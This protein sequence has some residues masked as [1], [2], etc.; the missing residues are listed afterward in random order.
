MN[1]IIHIV[2]NT[3]PYIRLRSFLHSTGIIKPKEPKDYYIS[4]VSKDAPWT[5]VAYIAS[6]FYHLE[7]DKFLDSHQNKREA[8]RIVNELN[9]LGY[10]VYVQEF[11]STREIPVLKNVK[12]IFGH[13]PNLFRAAEKYPQALVIRYSTGSYYRHQNS[14][15]T[16]MTDYVNKKYHSNIPY[17]RMVQT[18]DDVEKILKLSYK[19]L[20]V[21]SKYTIS[22]YPD[23]YKNKICLIHQSTQVSR[24]IEICDATENEF[25]YLGSSGNL[26]K[27]IPLLIDY[28]TQHEEVTLH[29]VG[30]MEADYM[31][32][33][34]EEVTSNIIFHGFMNVNDDEFIQ[35]VKRCNF[36]IF[37]SGSEGCPGSVLCAMQFGLIPIVTPWAAFDE[38][39]EYGYLMDD[40]WTVESVEKGVKWA[41]SLQ[42]DERYKLKIKCKDYV[43]EYYNLDRFGKEFGE[44]ISSLNAD[45]Q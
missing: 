39:K 22:T 33:I 28:F 3:F 13:N 23:E 17:R 45:I 2:K 21:G 8:I 38:I 37:P 19:V 31:E 18:G 43:R 20:Q 16:K 29:I 26:L 1:K 7:D 14:Q 12:I 10:N 25:M 40:K 24:D 44:F 34:K 41:L 42:A 32:L 4:K 6:V 11:T 36:I 35:I 15:I 5:Y 30:P 27:G 9:K